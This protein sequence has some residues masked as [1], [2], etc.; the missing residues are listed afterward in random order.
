M[1][2]MAVRHHDMG[3]APRRRILVAAESGIVEERIDHDH[4]APD[5]DPEGRMAKPG[6]LHGVTLPFASMVTP[7]IAAHPDFRNRN[8]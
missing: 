1:V 2:V 6:D 8:A 5:V 3:R 7:M 4:R